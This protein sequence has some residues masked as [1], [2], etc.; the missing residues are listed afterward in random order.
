MKL[1]PLITHILRHAWFWPIEF[2]LRPLTVMDRY[3]KSEWFELSA[4][5]VGSG[6]WGALIG[7]LLWL[8]NGDI[9]SIW[10]TVEAVVAEVGKEE[11]LMIA[12]SFSPIILIII[13]LL[14]VVPGDLI[15]FFGKLV[16]TVIYRTDSKWNLNTL[17]FT[18]LVGLPIVGLSFFILTPINHTLLWGIVLAFS[19][20]KGFFT[21]SS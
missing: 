1:Q 17:I 12:F 20:S 15:L 19:F 7:V 9:Y 18:W 16:I 21:V 8:N 3:K 2:L 6:L 11:L 14:L 13:L 4:S 5:L 10:I